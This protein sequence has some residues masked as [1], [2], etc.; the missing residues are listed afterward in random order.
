MATDMKTAHEPSVTELVTG[1]VNDA[2]QL[3]KQQFELLKHEV[4]E[5]MR[6]T[7]DAGLTLALGAGFALVGG[8]LFVLMLVYLTNWLIPELPLWACF[9]IW[10]LGLIAAGAALIYGAKTSFD[11]FNPLPD[12]TA[13]A[14][15]ENVQWIT[16][17]K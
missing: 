4:R 14:V 1:I 9:G 13:Q 8:L 11:K 12:E 7:R 3:L 5:D 6:K 15:K 17:P 10:S 2:Q 16:H